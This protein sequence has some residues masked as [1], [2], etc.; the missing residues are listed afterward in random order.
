MPQLLSAFIDLAE[1]VLDTQLLGSAELLR[2]FYKAFL[3]VDEQIEANDPYLS[4]AIAW[5]LSPAVLELTQARARFLADG[6]PE[7]VGELAIGGNGK[8]AFDRL[9]DLAQI[10]RPLA[11]LVVDTQQLSAAIKSFGLLH[12]FGPEPPRRKSLAVQTLLRDER[13]DDDEASAI[14]CVPARSGI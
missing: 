8:A 6:F 11:A 4:G 2:R 14:S 1:R 12:Y 10:H 7:A 9:L 5:G 13:S 3:I